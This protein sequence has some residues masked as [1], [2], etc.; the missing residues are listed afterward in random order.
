MT[1]YAAQVYGSWFPGSKEL[2]VKRG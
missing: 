1:S 2:Q